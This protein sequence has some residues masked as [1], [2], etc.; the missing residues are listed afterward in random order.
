[1]KNK[2]S[3]G[4]DHNS[5]YLPKRCIPYM[6]KPLLELVNQLIDFLDKHNIFNKSQFGFRKNKSTNDAI[7]TIIENIIENL[8]DKTKYNCV[9]IDLSKAFDCI[10]HNILMD[11]LYKYGVRGIPHELIKS[12]LTNGTQQVKIAHI[13]NNQ[14]K[15]YLSGSLLVRYGV[16]QGSVLGPLFFIL[17]INDIPH[18]TQGR[19]IMYA[20]DTSILNMG[21]DI[22]ELQH[23]TSVYLGAVEQYFQMNNLFI[24]PSKMH[25]ILFQTKQCKRES[26][27]KILIKNREITNVK[28]ANFLGVI[29][30]STLSWEVHIERTCSRISLNLFIINR[31]Q[32]CSI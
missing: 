18:L 2:K 16:P 8:N 27:L 1:M 5:P 32:K 7:A 30:G 11:K 13:E 22:N 28:S 21:Q 3:A 26:E 17:Y 20:D 10:Q 24:N 15:E 29:I 9:L 6:I 23:I 25:Y 14:M 4:L 12:Y 19:S 31:Y